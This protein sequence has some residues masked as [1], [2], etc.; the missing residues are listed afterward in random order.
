MNV[1]VA[2]AD[3][4]GEDG[5]TIVG[6]FIC[7]RL[8]GEDEA[9]RQLVGCGVEQCYTDPK[10]RIFVARLFEAALVDFVVSP[11]REEVGAFF[12]GRKDGRL[13]MVVDCR[14]SNAHFST[15]DTV[16]LCTAEALS[17][18]ELSEAFYHLELPQKLRCY[19]GLPPLSAGEVCEG[20]ALSPTSRIFPKVKGVAYGM[21]SCFVV[22]PDRPS[23]YSCGGWGRGLCH[24]WRTRPRFCQGNTSGVC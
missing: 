20:I 17:R 4:L 12:V 9:R 2:L 11:P 10:L 3:L 5:Q 1:P 21:E 19:F 6:E 8:L 23:A 15:P 16:A 24:V 7:S 18:I 14:R 13:R 22:V